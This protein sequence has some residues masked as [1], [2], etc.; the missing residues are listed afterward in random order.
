VVIT[1]SDF[2]EANGLVL[3][4]K[5]EESFNGKPLASP[6]RTVESVAINAQL[7]QKLFQKP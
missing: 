7:D 6:A 4:Y 2:R 1:Y 5:I 3:P